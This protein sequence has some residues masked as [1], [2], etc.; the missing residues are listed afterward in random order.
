[1]GKTLKEEIEIESALAE[2]QAE[3]IKNA[4]AAFNEG[5]LMGMHHAEMVYGK[6]QDEDKGK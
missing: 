2:F 6:E 5:Y 3:A 1:M 4:V